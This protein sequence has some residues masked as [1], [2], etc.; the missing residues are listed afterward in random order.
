MAI[1]RH[2]VAELLGIVLVLASTATQMFYVEPSQREIAWRMNAFAQQQNA[3]VLARTVLDSRI[4]T[5]K[6]LN[7]PAAD[8]TAAEAERTSTIARFQTA[9]A[10]ISDYVIA[11]Q[12]VEDMLQMVVLALFAIGTLLAG[13][14]RLVELLASSRRP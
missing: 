5:L 10:N 2:H 7:A 8:I 14:G 3:Q 6:A 4:A 11:K 9:D 13:Y 1:R 12:P